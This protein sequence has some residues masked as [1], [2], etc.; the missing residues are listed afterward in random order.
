MIRSK[1][2]FLLLLEQGIKK[3]PDK[4]KILEEYDL[5]ISELILE[6]SQQ[7]GNQGSVMDHVVKRLGTPDEIAALWLEEVSASPEKTKWLFILT[8]VFFFIGG[9]ALT[10]AYHLLEL[11]WIDGM[12]GKLTAIPFTIMMVYMFFWALLGYEIGKSF[13]HGGKKL[14]R[15]TFIWALAPNIL[16]MNLVLFQIIPRDWF[17]PLLS[18]NFILL[19]IGATV[20]LYPISWFGYRWGKKVSL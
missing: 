18:T 15:K 8:N 20:L 1:E 12:W 3:H 19:C 16:L 13:G 4:E 5:H 2:E 17:Q 6:L 11:K 9:S 10:L 14:L 7:E